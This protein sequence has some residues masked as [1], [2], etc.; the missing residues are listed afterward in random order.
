VL[1]SLTRDSRPSDRRAPV[2]RPVSINSDYE[3]FG[4]QSYAAVIARLTIL[5]PEIGIVVPFYPFVSR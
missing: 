3:M 5:E 2:V 4:E 1:E